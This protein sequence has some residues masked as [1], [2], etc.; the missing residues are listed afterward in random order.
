MTELNNNK[1][2]LNRRAGNAVAYE[3]TGPQ[4]EYQTIQDPDADYL[5]RGGEGVNHVKRDWL[6]IFNVNCDLYLFF[7]VKRDWGYLRE[8]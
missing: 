8:T 6:E 2:E 1:M 4:N 7:C 5:H 3:N